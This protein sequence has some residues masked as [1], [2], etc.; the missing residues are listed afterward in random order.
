[1][2]FCINRLSYAVWCF[3]RYKVVKEYVEVPG[4]KDGSKEDF[5]QF[6][7]SSQTEKGIEPPW[8]KLLGEIEMDSMP[9]GNRGTSFAI[10]L[11]VH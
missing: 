5:I 2:P 3:L 11:G 10:P 4:L 7:H 8:Y 9:Q 6:T 1:M